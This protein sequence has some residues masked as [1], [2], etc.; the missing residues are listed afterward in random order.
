MPAKA[1]AVALGIAQRVRRDRPVPEGLEGVPAGLSIV[2][3]QLAVRAVDGAAAKGSGD[4]E[5]HGQHVVLTAPDME[6]D[7]LDGVVLADAESDHLNS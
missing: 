5:D 1:N 4:A 7:R 6:H 3:E 2:G